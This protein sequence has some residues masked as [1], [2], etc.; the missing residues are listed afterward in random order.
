MGI[1][2]RN[3]RLSDAALLLEWRNSPS[4][5]EYSQISEPIR[6]EEHLVWLSERL[7]RI[8]VEPFYLF[9]LGHKSV[10]MSRLDFEIEAANKFVIS[11]LVDPEQHGKGIGTTILNLTC[12][13][14]FKLHPNSTIIAKV[15]RDNSVSKKLFANAS[16]E[17]KDSE[18]NF[19]LLE[20][21]D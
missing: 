9:E 15:H 19:L 5:R 11:I 1:T 7:A 16:F 2:K 12:Q 3:A 8:R 4:A 18:G 17:L 20:K 6:F 21:T 14:F 13:N 10:G